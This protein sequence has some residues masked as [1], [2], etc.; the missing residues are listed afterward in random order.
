MGVALPVA[1][2]HPIPNFFG[3]EAKQTAARPIGKCV[4]SFLR[5]LHPFENVRPCGSGHPQIEQVMQ[6]FLQQEPM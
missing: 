5:Y 4:R 6:R 1:L 3:I 2:Q